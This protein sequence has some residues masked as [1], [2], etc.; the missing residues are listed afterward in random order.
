VKT[1]KMKLNKN[2]IIDWLKG[3]D[4]EL[5]FKIAR[6]IRDSIFGKYVYLRGI[7]EFSNVCRQD[8]LYCGIR[9]SNIKVKR[10]RLSPIE[11]INIAIKSHENTPGLN[12]IVLQSGEDTYYD[13]EMIGNIIKD[14]KAKSNVAITLSLGERNEEELEYWRECGADRY[15][16]RI[17]TFDVKRYSKF[18]PERVFSDRF[19]LIKKIKK[20]GYEAGSGLII[21]LPNEDIEYLAESLINIKKLGLAMIGEGPLIPHP[22]TPFKDEKYGDLNTSLRYLALLRIMNPGAN[23]PATSALA[24]ISQQ[25]RYLGL[26]AGANVI[27]PS[28]T[29]I[30]NRLDYNIYPGK[31]I[32]CDCILEEI[33]IILDDIKHAGLSVATD[34]L[35]ATKV[36]G[37]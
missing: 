7:I 11:I 24:S 21:G 28:I 1:V 32:K 15:L 4:D 13:K 26:M 17:E 33:D 6:E 2:T 27:M 30:K 3:K 14:I 25:G 36:E 19:E 31:N 22:D 8:C 16:L 9:K 29:P 37:Y 20:M 12:T 34:I 10:Y 18:R 5:L 35:G 23:L